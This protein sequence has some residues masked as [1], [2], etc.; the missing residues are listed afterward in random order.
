MI[1]VFGSITMNM[2]LKVEHFSDNNEFPTFATHQNISLGGKGAIQAL[3][4]ARSGGEVSL[5]GKVGDDEFATTL[6]NQLRRENITTSG[7]DQSD[8]LPTSINIYIEDSSG[9]I[10]AF[11]AQAANVD[12]SSEQIPEEVLSNETFILTQTEITLKENMKLLSRAKKA[13][14]TTIMNL[15]P[16]LN[17]SQELLDNLDYMI[18]NQEE[19]LKLSEKLGLQTS[20]NAIKLA[21]GLSKQGNL[22]CIVTIGTNGSYAYT[23]EGEI[24]KVKALD[25][26]KVIDRNGAQDAYCGVFTASLK[27]NMSLPQAMKRASIAGSLTCTK[28]KGSP[29]L[30]IQ[31]EIDAKINDL[32]DPKKIST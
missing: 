19:A 26:E 4:A 30:P 29:A 2:H 6:L 9:E 25:I 17:F 24:W 23:T 31:E 15:S 18:V 21:E 5:I 14:A 22:T 13:G 20:N 7:I 11:Y 1:I 10:K 12:A 3:A 32:S 16:S 8:E 28:I 27:A